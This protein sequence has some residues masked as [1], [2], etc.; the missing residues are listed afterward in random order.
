[1]RGARI[2]AVLMAVI[3]AA[4]RAV[5]PVLGNLFA[6]L[7]IPGLAAAAVFVEQTF[8]AEILAADIGVE[9]GG[10]QALFRRGVHGCPLATVTMGTLPPVFRDYGFSTF[11]CAILTEV[12]LHSA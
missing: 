9:A 2:R 8:F 1:M 6:V 4:R 7:R 10:W 3:E 11:F 5:R 12:G